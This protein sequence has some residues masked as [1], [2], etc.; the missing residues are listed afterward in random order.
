MDNARRA[1]VNAL[2]KQEKDGYSNLVLSAALADFTG[3]QRDRMFLTAIFYGTVER[4]ITLDFILQKFLPK[5][6]RKLDAPVRAIL[7]SGLYQALYL[8]SVPVPAAISECVTLTKQMGK[9]SAAGMVNAV[10]RRACAGDVTQ[11]IFVDETQRLSVLY[12]VSSQ[13]A[14][15]LREKLPEQCENILRAG[16]VLPGLCVRVNS[17]VTTVEEVEQ[18]FAKQEI[19]TQRGDVPGSLYVRFKGD[20]TQ[21]KLFKRGYF[22]VQSEA[23]QCACAAL[24]PKPGETVYDLCAAPGG[25]SA[26]LAQYMQ[27]KGVLV[28]SDAAPN[29][30]SLIED[31]LARTGVTCAQVLAGDASVPRAE[32][33]GQPAPES[34]DA[35]LCDVPCSGLGVLAKKPDIRQKDLAG[36]DELVRLQQR[37]LDASAGYVKRGGRLVYSTCTVN[38][39]EN[40]AVVSAFLQRHSDFSPAL[41][42]HF[43]QGAS[44]EK[45]KKFVTLYPF[46]TQTDGF[47]VAL[48]DKL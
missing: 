29:R 37:I 14:S 9:T 48:L 41:P 11:E 40:E 8:N 32:I 28:S 5:P 12:S 15:L 47:F 30:L 38:P 6:L 36:L 35:V 44:V 42:A 18:A 25:K 23:S 2:M 1:A 4:Q 27:N 19:A 33:A 46:C 21:T 34:A 17:L 26:T 39:D 10:L 45:S 20:I 24:C 16:F 7:R 3:S 31:V 43:P 22:H 13:I